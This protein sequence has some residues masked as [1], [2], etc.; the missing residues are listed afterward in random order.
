MDSCAKLLEVAAKI[1]RTGGSVFGFCFAVL[2]IEAR[3]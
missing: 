3:A 1:H 2:G